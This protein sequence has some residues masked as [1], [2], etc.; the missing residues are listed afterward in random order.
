M[1]EN[2]VLLLYHSRKMLLTLDLNAA[3]EV[4]L[5]EFG[6]CPVLKLRPMSED[7]RRSAEDHSGPIPLVTER[8]HLLA[9]SAQV[10]A[11]R[12]LDL[13]EKIVHLGRK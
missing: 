1:S 11:T 2:T 13:E 8:F 9:L 7:E 5:D 4:L 3:I 6:T 12:R 10:G